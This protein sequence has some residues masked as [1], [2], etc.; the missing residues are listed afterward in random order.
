MLA[1]KLDTLTHENT[2]QRQETND[3]AVELQRK[4]NTDYHTAVRLKG[5]SPH[6]D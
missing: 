3:Q 2:L 1:Y 6:K 5:D 4:E